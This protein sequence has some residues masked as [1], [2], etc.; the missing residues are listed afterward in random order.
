MRE[1]INDRL[2]L[3]PD[4]AAWLGSPVTESEL[5]MRDRE[6]QTRRHLVGPQKLRES[7]AAAS[8]N[9][10]ILTETQSTRSIIADTTN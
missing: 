6:V 10:N 5:A 1:D 8:S 7:G 9:K 2:R 3:P 4:L